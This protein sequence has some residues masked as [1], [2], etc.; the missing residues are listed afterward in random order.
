MFLK[1][2]FK[3]WSTP[4]LLQCG[5]YFDCLKDNTPT[6]EIPMR[7]SIEPY[8]METLASSVETQVEGGRQKM[9]TKGKGKLKEKVTE[10]PSSDAFVEVPLSQIL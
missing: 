8:F 10:P 5:W 9:V 1:D 2:L 6:L 7:E 4:H 3:D